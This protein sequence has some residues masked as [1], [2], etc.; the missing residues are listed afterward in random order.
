[1]QK[2]WFHHIYKIAAPFMVSAKRVAD[3]LFQILENKQWE[4]GK[5]MDRKGSAG[6]LKYLDPNLKN[7]FWE[8]IEKELTDLKK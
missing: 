3:G 7:T 6:N 4:G 1:M 5:M 2:K 8:V